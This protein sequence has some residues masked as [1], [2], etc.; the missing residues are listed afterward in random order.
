MLDLS[1]CGMADTECPDGLL[2]ITKCM[3]GAPV[4]MS[5]PYFLGS[6]DFLRTDL[7]D[8]PAGNEEDHETFL[9]I[10]PISGAVVT[11]RKRLQVNIPLKNTPEIIQLSSVKDVVLPLLWLEEAADLDQENADIIKDM[12]IN[13]VN[14]LEGV[15]W[16]MVAIGAA[17]MLTSIGFWVFMCII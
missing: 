13:P 9:D 15:Q 1:A 16:T 8:F 14:A 12:V 7:V 17:M 5:S 10:E 4:L 3:G 2:D 11:A 6:P